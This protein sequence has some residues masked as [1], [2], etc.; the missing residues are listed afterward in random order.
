MKKLNVAMIGCVEFSIHMLKELYRSKNV[1][2]VAIVTKTKSDFN[3]DFYSLK[4]FAVK[5]NISFFI[6]S[7]KDEEKIIKF[8]KK[9]D[10]DVGFCIGWSHILGLKV[11]NIPKLGF[12]GYHPANLPENKGRHP[13]IWAIALG[14]KKTASSFFIMNKFADQGAII[15]KKPIYIDKKDNA[16]KLYFKLILTAKKQLKSILKN[17]SENNLKPIKQEK[18]L[19]IRGEKEQN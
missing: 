8:F 9:F 11:L 5:K 18:I 17:I 15:D 13:I 4:G 14:I 19:V 6:S 3:S 2:I 12:I 10:I 16:K 7:G 1:N